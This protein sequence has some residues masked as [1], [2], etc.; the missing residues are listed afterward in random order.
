MQINNWPK[1]WVFLL[2]QVEK[3]LLISHSGYALKSGNAVSTLALLQPASATTSRKGLPKGCHLHICL[4]GYTAPQAQ[5]EQRCSAVYWMLSSP[6]ECW[7][8]G[9]NKARGVKKQTLLVDPSPHNCQVATSWKQV[10]ALQLE[11]SLPPSHMQTAKPHSS[12]N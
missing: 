6:E 8:Q 1:I 4:S 3:K 10:T 9:R 2:E 11:C 7:R 5:Q 12:H